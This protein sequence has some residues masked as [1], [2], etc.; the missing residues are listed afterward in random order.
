MSET[1]TNFSINSFPGAK[2][3]GL[4]WPAMRRHLV[5][6]ARACFSNTQD[7]LGIVSYLVGEANVAYNASICHW[8]DPPVR[9]GSPSGLWIQSLTL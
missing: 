5:D 7:N 6:V 1:K 3:H 4:A 9:D 2:A 8:W